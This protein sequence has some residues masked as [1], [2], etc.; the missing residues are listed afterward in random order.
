MKEF[1]S[2]ALPGYGLGLEN[3]LCSLGRVCGCFG[4]GFERVMVFL[5][6]SVEDPL[7]EP[8]P[9]CCKHSF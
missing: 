8:E 2:S 3:V 9:R 1:S 4:L 7:V 5:R 6:W